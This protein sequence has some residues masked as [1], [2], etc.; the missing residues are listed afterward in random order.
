MVE[1]TLRT[2]R[3][4]PVVHLTLR[5]QRAPP[6]VQL[7]LRLQRAP[8]VV[9]LTLRPHRA[10]PVVQLQ[11]SPTQ[12]CNRYRYQLPVEIALLALDA[13]KLVIYTRYDQS[14]ICCPKWCC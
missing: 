4:P 9:H 12:K 5:P 14:C 6:V 1:L 3:A 10:P 8:P 7:T 13:R 11:Q 2:Q